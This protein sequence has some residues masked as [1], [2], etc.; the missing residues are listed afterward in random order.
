MRFLLKFMELFMKNQILTLIVG[1]T[2][3]TAGP[4]FA[5]EKDN[6][7]DVGGGQEC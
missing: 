6:N 5:M 2:V 7:D 4:A 3:L 1:A